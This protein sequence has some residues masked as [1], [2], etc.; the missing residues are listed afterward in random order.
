[1]HK[2]R[3]NVKAN[4]SKNEKW[5]VANVKTLSLKGI[6]R[7]IVVRDAHAFGKSRIT[8]GPFYSAVSALNDLHY[9]L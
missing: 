3:F 9:F 2:S 6:V 7:H 1:M 5:S 8:L 4:I